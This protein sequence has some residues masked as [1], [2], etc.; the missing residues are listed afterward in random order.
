MRNLKPILAV[1]IGFALLVVVLAQ[2]CATQNFKTN[3]YKTLAAGAAIYELG[4]PAFLELHQK[5]LISDAEKVRGK[6]LA[7]K[8]WGA[9]HAATGAL[10]AYDA[11]DTAENQAK[12]KT[13]LDEAARCLSNLSAYIQ[14]FLRR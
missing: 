7:T 13:A 14:P 3:G 5:G 10:I 2:G 6:E 8:Y 1:A 4:Y 9:Y 12:V 11:V